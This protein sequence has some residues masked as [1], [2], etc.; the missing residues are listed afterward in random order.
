MSRS[1]RMREGALSA[2][3][4]P[5]APPART[6]LV[7]VDRPAREPGVHHRVEI[8]RT[9]IWPTAWSW[10]VYRE[11]VDAAGYYVSGSYAMRR[12]AA[13]T[14]DRARRKALRARRSMEQDD[15]RVEW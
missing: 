8:E 13:F 11:E 15:V 14:K 7:P 9:G 2:A 12:G 5:A 3:A 1:E 6:R 4:T 10:A